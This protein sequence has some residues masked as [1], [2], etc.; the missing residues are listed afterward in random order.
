MSPCTIQE[1]S[2]VTVLFVV[3]SCTCVYRINTLFRC[4]KSCSLRKGQSCHC[5]KSFLDKRG[6]SVSFPGSQ[7]DFSF[8]ETLPNPHLGMSVVDEKVKTYK[9]ALVHS[10]KSMFWGQDENRVFSSKLY[11]IPNV[12][13]S[14]VAE[15]NAP[16]SDQVI[17]ADLGNKVWKAEQEQLDIF[18]LNSGQS[19]KSSWNSHC[20]SLCCIFFFLFPAFQ[21][22]GIFSCLGGNYLPVNS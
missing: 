4:F 15:E 1:K 7:C 18:A 20:F 6:R 17:S 13:L 8:P 22:T 3:F 10:S 2:S 21:L 9:K 16:W 11:N 12:P 14:R 19:S 5:Q